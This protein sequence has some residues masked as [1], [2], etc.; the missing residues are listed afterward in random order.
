MSGDPYTPANGASGDQSPVDAILGEHVEHLF[1]YCNELIGDSATAA[2]VAEAALVAAQSVLLAPDKLRAWL[3]ALARADAL[4]M[5]AL[6]REDPAG[7]VR[8]PP[9]GKVDDLLGQDEPTTETIYTT[10]TAATNAA[11]QVAASASTVPGSKREVLELVYRHGIQPDD[12]TTVLGLPPDSAQDLLESAEVEILAEADATAGS[13]EAS[14]DELAD[15]GA[16]LDESAVT[17]V[18]GGPESGD[19]S[20][21]EMLLTEEAG[22][23][24]GTEASEGNSQR[25][26]NPRRE[27]PRR[28]A[29]AAFI[30]LPT[31]A[32]AIVGVVFLIPPVLHHTNYIWLPTVIRS[33]NPSS[34]LGTSPHSQAHSSDQRRSR[35]KRPYGFSEPV[36]SFPGRTPAATRS[37]SRTHKHPSPRPS[38]SP[39]SGT[40]SAAPSPT[41]APSTNSPS[42][43][44]SPTSPSAGTSTLS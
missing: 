31:T 39:S 42:P 10:D 20:T 22:P 36:T 41:P 8:A 26:D 44:S 43:T 32:V 30:A 14:S 18:V 21:L 12:L 11:A 2:D 19:N 15:P 34:P 38:R 16:A 37:P 7:V 27:R 13:L 29:R 23:D 1:D 28:R 3:F 6:E 5:G 9:R 4:R 33:E 24:G 40:V 25:V 35:S 17:P